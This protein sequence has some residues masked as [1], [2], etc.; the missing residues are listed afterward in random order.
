M[1]LSMK[2]KKSAVPDFMFRKVGLG[3]SLVMGD[4]PRGARIEPAVAI[5]NSRKV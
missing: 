2:R 1:R 4:Y 3:L 5:K